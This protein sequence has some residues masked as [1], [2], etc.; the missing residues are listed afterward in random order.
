LGRAVGHD[1]PAVDNGDTVRR[2]GG[3]VLVATFNASSSWLGKTITWDEGVFT[4]E[5]H[6]AITAGDVLHYDTGGQLDWANDG[7]RAFVESLARAT[8]ASAPPLAAVVSAP[9]TKHRTPGWVFAILGAAVVLAIVLAVALAVVIGLKSSTVNESA[10]GSTAAAEP[11][12]TWVQVFSWQGGGPGN[13]I[14][15]S[16]SFTLEGGHQRA[17]TTASAVTGGGT[18]PSAF[19]T[20][21]SSD[22]GDATQNLEMPSMGTW[23]P[24]FYRP[25]G[26]YHLSS[27]TLDCTWTITISELR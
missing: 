3:A 23:E 16:A 6:G 5:G 25:A 13:D 26:S 22:G 15:D 10:G 1:Q 12:G 18:S 20:M 21:E 4:L 11:S 14:R 7:M 24:D 8:P 27:I 2:S 19:W 17:K 9:A